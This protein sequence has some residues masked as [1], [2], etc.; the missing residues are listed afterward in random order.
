MSI[1][2]KLLLPRHFLLLLSS[3]RWSM[4]FATATGMIKAAMSTATGMSEVDVSTTTTVVGKKIVVASFVI[5][6]MGWTQVAS[7]N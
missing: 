7:M 4:P 6:G 2:P 5:E 1:G 3:C